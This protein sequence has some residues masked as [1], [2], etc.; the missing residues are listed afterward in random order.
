MEEAA[1]YVLVAAKRKFNLQ[2]NLEPVTKKMRI[3]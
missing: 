3:A 2:L 1:L